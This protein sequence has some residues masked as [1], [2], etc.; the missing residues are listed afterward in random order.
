V[1]I[2][3]DVVAIDALGTCRSKACA[4]ISSPASPRSPKDWPLCGRC[5]A[6]KEDVQTRYRGKGEEREASFGPSGRFEVRGRTDGRFVVIDHDLAPGHRVVGDETFPTFLLA[7]ARAREL[8]NPLPLPGSVCPERVNGASCPGALVLSRGPGRVR[9]HR[10]ARV[11]VPA[12][13]EFVKC[14]SCGTEWMTTAER[15]ET[16]RSFEEQRYRGFAP[17]P[18]TRHR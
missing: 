16:A 15:G 4:G 11:V 1:E 7:A 10:G 12:S 9:T 13:L 18:G 8:A 14:P 17:R 3:G 6:L 5:L 2:T